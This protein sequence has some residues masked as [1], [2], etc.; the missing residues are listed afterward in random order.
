MAFF[1]LA[2]HCRSSKRHP[3]EPVQSEQELHGSEIPKRASAMNSMATVDEHE[4][5]GSKP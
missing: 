2:T 3:I 4:R 5:N 1:I